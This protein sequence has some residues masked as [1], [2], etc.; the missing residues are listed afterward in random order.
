MNANPH[1]SPESDIELPQNQANVEPKVLNNIRNAWC[2]TLVTGIMILFVILFSIFSPTS[3][4]NPWALIDVVLIFG[5]AYGI[6][7]KSR[8]CAL[9]MLIYFAVSKI[10]L[11]LDGMTT[12][13]NLII[14]LIFFFF[15]FKGVTGT[16]AYHK[17]LKQQRVM[18]VK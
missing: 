5:I 9:I 1:P 6:Y 8:C 12:L 11:F 14:G 16:F 2:A 4:F 10:I 17:H 15:Y 13:S 7:R 3:S 18:R